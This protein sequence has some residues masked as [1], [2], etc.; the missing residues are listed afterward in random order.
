M[1]ATSPP[2]PVAA[3]QADRVRAHTQPEVQ[4]Q[5]DRQL[6]ERITRLAADGPEAISRRLAELDRESDMERVLE[7]N[8][9]A[10]ALT[11]LTLGSPSTAGGCCCPR[12]SCR[13]CSSTASRAGAHRSPCCAAWGSGPVRRSTLSAMPL[14][15]SAATSKTSPTAQASRSKPP[16]RSRPCEHR[17]WESNRLTVAPDD[18]LEQPE[19]ALDEG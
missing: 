2:S 5:L 1:S 9:S 14:R 4:E 17:C 12:W 3:H 7:I 19:V 16:G 8:A 18:L 13:S 10:L 6:A 15:S 11:G